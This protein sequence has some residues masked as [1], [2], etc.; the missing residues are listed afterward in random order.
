VIPELVVRYRIGDL[1]LGVNEPLSLTP[2][3]SEPEAF[4][5]APVFDV[6]GVLAVTDTGWAF[7]YPF[8]YL[9]RDRGE[10]LR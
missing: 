3:G 1:E 4:D 7:A 8:G 10:R 9:G 2:R 5:L 6:G